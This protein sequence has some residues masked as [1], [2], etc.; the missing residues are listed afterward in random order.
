MKLFK[1]DL[2]N[3]NECYVVAENYSKVEE[4]FHNEHP[5]DFNDYDLRSI[6]FVSDDI[7]I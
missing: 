4:K 3:G 6:D 2:Y 1:I 5:N 7:I